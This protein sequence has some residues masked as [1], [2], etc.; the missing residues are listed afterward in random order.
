MNEDDNGGEQTP[1]AITG[2]VGLWFNFPQATGETATAIM[3]HR[4]TPYHEPAF[5][6]GKG[7]LKGSRVDRRARQVDTG[8]K[9]NE[10]KT[11]NIL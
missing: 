4:K 10:A 3:G 7:V 1:A 8:E 5:G 11:A 6:I 2:L 9:N